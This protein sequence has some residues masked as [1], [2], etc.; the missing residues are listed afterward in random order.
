MVS[1]KTKALVALAFIGLVDVIIPLP[2]LGILLIYVVLEKP[3][4]FVEWV[5]RIY[6][7]SV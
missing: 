7:E 5:E 4:W 2:L 3:S 1:F 6:P